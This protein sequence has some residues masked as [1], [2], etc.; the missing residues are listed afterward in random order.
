MKILQKIELFFPVD[1]VAVQSVKTYRAGKFIRFYQ[2][3]KVTDYKE[4]LKI[5]AK[6]QLPEG[7]ELFKGPTGI[8]T[9][10]VFAPPKSFP[11]KKLA[12][13]GQGWLFRKI[14]RPD[15]TDNLHKALLDAL[16]KIIWEDDAIIAH[17]TSDK[18][19]GPEPGIKLEVFA[20][21]EAV[22]L[23]KTL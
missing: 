6:K 8:K 14:T 11:K 18:F 21:D 4:N 17:N 9:T 15:L 2:P 10:F 23:T 19:Y 22:Q 13:M 12:L 5:L 1:P 16:T 3:S 7:F 20:L